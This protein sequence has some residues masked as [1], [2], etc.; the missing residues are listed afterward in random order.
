MCNLCKNEKKNRANHNDWSRRVLFFPERKWLSTHFRSFSQQWQLPTRLWRWVALILSTPIYYS[1]A[2][3]WTALMLLKKCNFDLNYVLRTSSLS[4]N[5][6]E[7]SL[8]TFIRR[9]EIIE[10]RNLRLCLHSSTKI[11]IFETLLDLPDIPLK[12]RFET[13]PIFL[14]QKFKI[15]LT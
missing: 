3:I 12:S 11:M 10:K 15:S 13:D 5:N 2:C 9:L 4:K 1:F 7:I 14:K 8:S 6:I